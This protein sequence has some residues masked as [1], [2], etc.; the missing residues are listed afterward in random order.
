MVI[1]IPF[2]SLKAQ[3]GMKSVSLER[4]F[5]ILNLQEYPYTTNHVEVSGTPF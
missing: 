4:F 2:A 3:N 1:P 5:S